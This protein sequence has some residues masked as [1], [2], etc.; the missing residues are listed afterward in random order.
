[1]IDEGELRPRGDRVFVQRPIFLTVLSVRPAA[2]GGLLFSSGLNP[3]NR[4]LGLS[5]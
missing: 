3:G 2:A 1:M 5:Q 4:C